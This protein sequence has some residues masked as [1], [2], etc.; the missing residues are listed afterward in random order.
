MATVSQISK[1]ASLSD[2][3]AHI[4]KNSSSV[5]M[6]KMLLANKILD[7][8]MLDAEATDEILLANGW[9]CLDEIT[10]EDVVLDKIATEVNPATRIA[11]T[12]TDNLASQ[13]LQASEGL[14]K[15]NF[16]TV[17]YVHRNHD[18]DK[19]ITELTNFIKEKATIEV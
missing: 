17:L 6:L 1:S 19:F 12:F 14:M 8:K 3:Q 7:L 4:T 16:A 13:G 18:T 5:P 15:I 2:K 11:A 10:R 9:L